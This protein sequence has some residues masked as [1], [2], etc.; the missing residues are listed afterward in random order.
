M[1]LVYLTN[2]ITKIFR[3]FFA[4]LATIDDSKINVLLIQYFFSL[5]RI[6]FFGVLLEV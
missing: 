5:F 2:S 3:L 4:F 1:F 6:I